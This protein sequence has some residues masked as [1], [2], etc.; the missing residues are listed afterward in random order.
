MFY[1][2]MKEHDKGSNGLNLDS[3]ILNDV[4]SNK[5]R[6]EEI[7]FDDKYAINVDALNAPDINGNYNIVRKWNIF[8]MFWLYWGMIILFGAF[9][10]VRI[11]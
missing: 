4:Q 10:E 1:Q 5:S 3:A 9:N 6:L 11:T 7:L 8:L 2:F